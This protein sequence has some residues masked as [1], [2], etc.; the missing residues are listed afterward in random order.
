MVITPIS[1]KKAKGSVY[2]SSILNSANHYAGRVSITEVDQPLKTLARKPS[3]KTVSEI[4]KHSLLA[5]S[6]ITRMQEYYNLPP[7]KKT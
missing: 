7:L 3:Q 1:I 2:N 4:I 5:S 6:M